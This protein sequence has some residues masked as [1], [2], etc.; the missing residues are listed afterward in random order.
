MR[1]FVR[2]SVRTQRLNRRPERS[3][4]SSR[5]AARRTRSLMETARLPEIDEVREEDTVS[6]LLKLVGEICNLDCAYCYE[7]R[8]PY[9]GNRIIDPRDV[10]RLVDRFSG[11]P[12]R[13]ELHG[14][15]PLLYPIDKMAQVVDIAARARN[16]VG[17]SMQTNATRLDR[18]WLDLFAPVSH[19]M[20]IGVSIDGPDDVNSWRL[21]HLG[22]SAFDRIVAGLG[23][24]RDNNVRTGLIAVVTQKSLGR[25]AQILELA[26]RFENVRLL[27]LVPCYDFGVGQALSTK[28]SPTALLAAAKGHA[29]GAAWAVSPSAYLDSLKRS[30]EIWTAR[31]YSRQFVLEPFLAVMQSLLGLQTDTC[32]YSTVKCAHV[33]TLYPDGQVGSCDEL[34]KT[35]ACYGSLS[36][37]HDVNVAFGGCMA[38]LRAE[39]Q[40]EKCASCAYWTTCRGGCISTRERFRKVDREDE[41]CDYRKGLID[42]VGREIAA[43]EE[44]R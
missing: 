42:F 37:L 32:T 5:S 39:K 25:E 14:G 8:K 28:R 11:R 1:S 9:A 12:L 4:G 35:D 13:L 41:Y 44:A 2:S 21:D 10:D 30:Y 40:M 3:G 7:R 29:F 43:A 24:L 22:C 15:E 38:A 31:G 33:L 16:V 17:V 18:T 23:V 19:K 36:E 27:K 6:I 34:D 26:A 20:E